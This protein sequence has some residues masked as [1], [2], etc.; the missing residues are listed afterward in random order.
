MVADGSVSSSI[1]EN[2]ISS[3]LK[4]KRGKPIIVNVFATEH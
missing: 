2:E 1:G 3:T 4:I